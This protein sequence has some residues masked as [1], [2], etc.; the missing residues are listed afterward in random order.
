[1][2]HFVLFVFLAAWALAGGG[3]GC[4]SVPQPQPV[5]FSCAQF[6]NSF[7]VAY[8][9][10]PGTASEQIEPAFTVQDC[11]W[12][13]VND[14]GPL[15]GD[16]FDPQGDPRS[17]WDYRIEADGS[18]SNLQTIWSPVDGTNA[19][20]ITQAHLTLAVTAGAR[21]TI[22]VEMGVSGPA[23]ESY[24]ALVVQCPGDVERRWS[25]T[26]P[27]LQWVA[28]ETG[29]CSVRA[30]AGCTQQGAFGISFADCADRIRAVRG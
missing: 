3:G 14:S 28:V 23:T 25:R 21:Y 4:S 11:E 1:M 13:G 8:I 5:P 2:T 27:T 19:T 18:F 26:D 29:T 15:D 7:H 16:E 6:P 10:G 30:D 22:S 17:D 9:F 24:P 20:A 12:N